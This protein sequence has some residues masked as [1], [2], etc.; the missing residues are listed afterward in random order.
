M[1]KTRRYFFYRT[2]FFGL[3][4]AFYLMQPGYAGAQARPHY[5]FRRLDVEWLGRES[6]AF[7]NDIPAQEGYPAQPQPQPT[8]T[9]AQPYPLT[10]SDAEAAPVLPELI[11]ED[12]PAL[13]S[14]AASASRSIQ[15][16][17]NPQ[18]NLGRY[19]L[20]GG[21]T[22]ALLILAISVYGAITLFIRRKD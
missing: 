17:V 16:P 21:F 11:G 5:I 3:V 14:T 6:P 7:R 15:Q 22:A 8:P 13:D 12:V 1:L 20:W 2:I 18:A 4:F 9:I 10:P 19:F